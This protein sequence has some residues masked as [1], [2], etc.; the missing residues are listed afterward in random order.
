MPPV[1]VNSRYAGIQR[2][3]AFPGPLPLPASSAFVVSLVPATTTHKSD[4]NGKYPEAAFV[5]ITLSHVD[6]QYCT[7]IHGRWLRQY[8]G[9][10]AR[11]GRVAAEIVKYT[12]RALDLAARLKSVS[13]QTVNKFRIYCPHTY[14]EIDHQ[15]KEWCLPCR[16]GDGA[17]GYA[18]LGSDVVVIGRSTDADGL[19]RW[20]A[21]GSIFH[22]I[23]H[24]ALF[25]G[26]PGAQWFAKTANA[27]LNNEIQ[28]AGVLKTDPVYDLETMDKQFRNT[29]MAIDVEW[30]SFDMT[31][32]TSGWIYDQYHFWMYVS[33]LYGLE[34]VACMLDA[35]QSVFVKTVISMRQRQVPIGTAYIRWV[36]AQALSTG[37]TP[38]DVME[39]YVRDV[40]SMGPNSA[41]PVGGPTG[42]RWFGAGGLVGSSWTPTRRLEYNGFMVVDVG[43]FARGR[44]VR[45]SSGDP[46]RIRVVAFV[47]GKARPGLV[48]G[49]FSVP[50]SGRAWLAFTAAELPDARTPEQVASSTR[51]T[52]ATS[53]VISIG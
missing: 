40:V 37:T 43:S 12:D 3:G 10:P 52:G 1:D 50:A 35:A 41:V 46:E 48:T 20:G 44:T 15:V 51:I 36:E 31:Y 42:W 26:E 39:R 28:A 17:A 45:W 19:D 14:T 9:D 27:F 6:G 47:D 22:E 7:F 49:A 16:P 5:P 11:L 38:A 23:A 24:A 33:A 13:T 30:R 18:R 8:G 25:V 4:A 29:G 34:G 2:P 32:W 53:F 21:I